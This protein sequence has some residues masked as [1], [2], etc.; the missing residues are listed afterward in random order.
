MALHKSFQKDPYEILD[1]STWRFFADED[2]REK[3]FDKLISPLV[4]GLRNYL[5]NIFELCPTNI[6]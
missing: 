3:G 1:P 4:A 6:A 5:Q 2:L